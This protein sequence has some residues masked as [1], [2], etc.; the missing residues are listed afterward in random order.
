MSNKLLRLELQILATGVFNNVKK[1]IICLQER[2]ESLRYSLIIFSTTRRLHYSE[3][4]VL[5]WQKKEAEA[6]HAYSW[7]HAHSITVDP[8][9]SGS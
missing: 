4:E 7:C 1:L 2:N 9:S 5:K 8:H 3:F 6:F